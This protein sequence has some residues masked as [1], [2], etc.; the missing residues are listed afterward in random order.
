MMI[1]EFEYN[2]YIVRLFKDGKIGI[3]NREGSFC[4]D[5]EN[6][7]GSYT[8]RFG[9]VVEVADVPIIVGLLQELVEVYMKEC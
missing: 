2:N 7:D 9:S 8:R 5:E 4:I 1:K 6:D 3:Y